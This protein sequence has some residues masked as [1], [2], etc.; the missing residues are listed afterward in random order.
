MHM[1]YIMAYLHCDGGQ[2]H[3]LLD[4]IIHHVSHL[5]LFELG[6]IA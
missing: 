5:L 3:V 6:F 1:Q 2:Q 4:H